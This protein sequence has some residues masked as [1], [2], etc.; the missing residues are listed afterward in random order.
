MFILI[1]VMTMTINIKLMMIIITAIILKI[2]III[3]AR[4]TQLYK[5]QWYKKKS[6]DNENHNGTVKPVSNDHLYDKIYYL[7]FIQ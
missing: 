2:L 3:L 6:C 4:I 7:L 5:H 1:T